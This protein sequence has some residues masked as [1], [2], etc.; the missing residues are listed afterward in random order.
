MII[1]TLRIIIG[2]IFLL[3]LPGYSL[4][5]AIRW[6]YDNEIE[7]WALIFVSS[8][9]LIILNVLLLDQTWEIS[10]IPI[11]TYISLFILFF[12]IIG[13][14]R[15]IKEGP[16]VSNIKTEEKIT[17]EQ[18]KIYN[19]IIFSCILGI[20]FLSVFIIL[21]RPD[22]EKFTEIYFYQEKLKLDN[23]E[24]EYLGYSGKVDF[25][26]SDI[27]VYLDLDNNS[28]FSSSELVYFES[29]YMLLT[30]ETFELNNTD[31]H[32]ADVSH[33]EILIAN[34]PVGELG[35]N[36]SFSFVISNHRGEP[37]NYTYSIKVSDD[38]IL[39]KVVALEDKTRIYVTFPT[40]ETSGEDK[41]SIELDT[42]ESIHFWERFSLLYFYE[43]AVT[44]ESYQ[45]ELNLT[46]DS[47][48][49]FGLNGSVNN[50]TEINKL[51][52]IDLN[53]NS[54]YDTSELVYNFTGTNISVQETF[55][56]E[57][58]SW[59][60][61][62]VTENKII[63]ANYPTTKVGINYTFSFIIENREIG[64]RNYTYTVKAT[65]DTILEDKVFVEY[66]EKVTV[67]FPVTET[68]GSEK[69][70]VTLDSSEQIYFEEQS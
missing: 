11:I 43:R 6:R 22:D 1:E 7:K 44:L 62:N 37:Y 27:S 4:L 38:T 51:V 55:V 31:W 29:N 18:N 47:F 61:K 50:S 60:I 5:F 3:I 13:S 36:Y 2:S 69:I 14:L 53:N 63:F 42:G 39:S 20:I 34:Y 9:G 32:I 46:N 49:F 15:Y 10:F 64:P 8:L 30:Q 65:D 28:I 17:P 19:S 45:Q 67:T 23:N 54:V 48:K 26:D 35:S 33:D 24:F 40:S 59:H 52:Y 21:A 68:N 58:S 16:I 57:N 56:V 66:K 70:Y 12:L 25:S 41:I